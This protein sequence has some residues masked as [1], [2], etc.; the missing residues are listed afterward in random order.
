VVD[1][2]GIIT[3]TQ[4]MKSCSHV[5]SFV[6]TLKLTQISIVALLHVHHSALCNIEHR[7]ILEYVYMCLN[8]LPKT[9]TNHFVT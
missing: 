4:K 7:G 5:I 9:Y 2:E 3:C 1:D 6:D 8:L